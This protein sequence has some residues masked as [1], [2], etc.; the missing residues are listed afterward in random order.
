MPEREIA[1]RELRNDVTRVLREAEAGATFTIT[2]RGRPVARLGPLQ[3]ARVDVDRETLK[4]IL[5]APLDSEELA[6]DLAA[7]E[8]PVDLER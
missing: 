5:L 6:E 4:R 1:Q 3:T 7:A 8:R 2:V